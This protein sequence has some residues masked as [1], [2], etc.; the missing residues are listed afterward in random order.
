MRDVVT[1]IKNIND[2]H[3]FFSANTFCLLNFSEFSVIPI[4]LSDVFFGLDLESI[5][6][7]CFS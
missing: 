5:K 6:N 4:N 7:K 2:E 3:S 1:Q